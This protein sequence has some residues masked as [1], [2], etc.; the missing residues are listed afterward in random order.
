MDKSYFSL[1]AISL[2]KHELDN[3]VPATDL[4]PSASDRPDQRSWNAGSGYQILPQQRIMKAHVRGIV[5]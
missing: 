1:I 4:F 2:L 5:T 3:F